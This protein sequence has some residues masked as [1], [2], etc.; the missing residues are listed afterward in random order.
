M[1]CLK[2]RVFSDAGGGW[3]RGF[4]HI[5]DGLLQTPRSRLLASIVES[6]FRGLTSACPA[7]AELVSSHTFRTKP[8]IS[9][10]LPTV[11]P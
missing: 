1:E 6:L 2:R 10:P 7:R 4:W 8:K 9:P 11:S 5:C 3:E